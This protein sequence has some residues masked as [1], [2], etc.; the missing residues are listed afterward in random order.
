MGKTIADL[1]RKTE[2]ATAKVKALY[3]KEMSSLEETNRDLQKK[4]GRIKDVGQTAWKGLK[5]SVKS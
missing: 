4:L 1:K 3:N 5:K 2:K